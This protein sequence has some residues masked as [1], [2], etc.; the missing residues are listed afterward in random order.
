MFVAS[1]PLTRVAALTTAAVLLA[2]F[3]PSPAEARRS[4]LKP[5]LTLK[6]RKGK[7]VIGTEE[8][9]I[10]TGKKDEETKQIKR[11][12]STK[13]RLKDGGRRFGFRTHT[14]IDGKGKMLTYDRWIDVKGATLRRRVFAF[15]GAWKL[16]VFAQQGRKNALTELNHKGP[17]LVLDPRSPTLVS[18]A[19]DRLVGKQEMAFVN[20]DSAEM[21]KLS[22]TAEHL[23]D[24]NGARYIR[25]H[26][27][28]TVGAKQRP[29]ALSVL[30]DDAGHTLQVVGLAGYSGGN[31]AFKPG[32]LIPAAA[33]GAQKVP[34]NED[35]PL[36]PPGDQ[37]AASKAAG[38]KGPGPK[39]AAPKAGSGEA[40]PAKAAPSK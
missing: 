16:V 24:A 40:A 7:R 12:F 2:C 15:K 33:K 28:G 37:P 25:Y 19:V 39:A 9:R 1:T 26:L 22:M 38:S 10:K 21:G 31:Q 34:V 27:K 14:I 29:V 30:R 20:A 5:V 11:Y 36:P 3:G 35:A 18:L 8:L 4:K 23:A 13:S 17:L 6:V 32:A